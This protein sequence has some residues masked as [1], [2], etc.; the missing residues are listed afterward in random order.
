MKKLFISLLLLFVAVSFC[1]AQGVPRNADDLWGDNTATNGAAGRSKNRQ[2]LASGSTTVVTNIAAIGQNVDGTP[3]YIA[4]ASVG[5][6]GG[7][8]AQVLYYLWV[9]EDGDLLI[10]SRLTLEQQSGFPSGDWKDIKDSVTGVT[11]VGEQT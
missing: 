11:T 7:A 2:T 1:Y 8:G 6:N 9:D 10:S 4:L 3:G 5:M